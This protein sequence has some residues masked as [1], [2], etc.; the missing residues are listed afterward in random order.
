MGG[1][2]LAEIPGNSLLDRVA[3]RQLGQDLLLEGRVRR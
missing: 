2:G 3:W 1:L